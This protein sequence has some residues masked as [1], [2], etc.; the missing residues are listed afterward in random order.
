MVTIPNSVGN[1]EQL[2]HLN[3][4][5]NGLKVLPESLG[6]LTK[7]ETLKLND[8]RELIMLPRSTSKLCGLKR[9]ENERCWE[10]RGM[11][12]GIG[13]GLSR[14]EKLST[15]VWGSEESENIEGLRCLSLLGGSLFIRI[16][17]LRKEDDAAL[18]DV[19]EEV[20]TNKTN[21]SELVLWFTFN[22][23]DDVSSSSSEQALRILKPP[24]NIESLSIWSYKGRR[25][26]KWMEMSD[27]HSSSSFPRLRAIQLQFMQNLEEWV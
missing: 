16:E 5:T 23:G 25:F 13:Q 24:S 8:C 19:E 11:P 9:L 1:S 4:S 27:P 10:L 18:H 20:L 6:N 2:R 26:P 21:L 22:G 17:V 3:L 12:I 14:L 7:L 15:W